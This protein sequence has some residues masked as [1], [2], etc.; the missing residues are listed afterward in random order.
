[1]EIY[2]LETVNGRVFRVAIA[3]KSQK[4]RLLNAVEK[5][6]SKSYEVFKRVDAVNNG[7]HDI[8]SFEQIAD[9]LQ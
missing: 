4:K 5:N 3:N 1:M 2:E 9:T 6:K 7:I 8:K